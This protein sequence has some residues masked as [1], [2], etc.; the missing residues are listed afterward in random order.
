MEQNRVTLNLQPLYEEKYISDSSR[1]L[2]A[3]QYYT[4]SG[5]ASGEVATYTPQQLSA[6]KAQDGST[7]LTLTL[8]STP[9][10]GYYTISVLDMD[11]FDEG[12]GE[13][14][15]TAGSLIPHTVP[16]GDGGVDSDS[17]G[18][19]LDDET[20]KV[21]AKAREEARHPQPSISPTPKAAGGL[22]RGTQIVSEVPGGLTA[23]R[24]T[25]NLN[26]PTLNVRY[27]ELR[28]DAETK[29]VTVVGKNLPARENGYDLV[30]LETD[31]QG[32]PRGDAVSY[33]HVDAAHIAGG[34]LE[35]AVGVPGSLLKTGSV[36]TAYLVYVDEQN[37]DTAVASVRFKV[38]AGESQDTADSSAT[39]RDET[40][41]TS[42]STTA[43]SDNSASAS[44]HASSNATD[45]SSNASRSSGADSTATRESQARAERRQQGLQALAQ[46][47]TMAPQTN[48]STGQS[49]LTSAYAAGSDTVTPNGEGGASVKSG[50]ASAAQPVTPT[51]GAKGLTPTRQTEGNSRSAEVNASTSQVH[52]G[53]TAGQQEGVKA[54]SSSEHVMEEASDYRVTFWTVGLVGLGL[55]AGAVWMAIRRNAFSLSRVFRR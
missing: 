40:G 7:L 10:E 12:Y 25:A 42:T 1:Y 26:A 55:V 2:V 13:F 41:T 36:Y 23:S 45:G 35:V 32:N 21:L 29:P 31:M 24:D 47:R 16:A 19:R 30:V 18:I 50:S 8:P 49:P 17:S 15:I 48:A 9:K 6:V 52:S 51:D 4:V 46:V 3:V 11:S 5:K 33:T 54:A 27:A 28:S 43:K 44:S 53:S 20:Q 14:K 22:E 37:N 38:S 34:E 39:R